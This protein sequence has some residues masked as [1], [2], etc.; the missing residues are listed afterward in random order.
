MDLRDL[1]S[2]DRLVGDL[3]SDLPRPI[4]TD[5]ARAALETARAT[6]L[7]G[8][9]ADPSVAAAQT[10]ASLQ[11]ARPR[12]VINATGVLLHTNLGRAPIHPKAADVAAWTATG[13]S[14][15]EIDLADGGRG[16]RTAYLEALLGTITGA[17]AALAVNNNAAAL[18][19]TLIALARDREVPV[20]RGELIEIGGSYRLPELM[21]A[22]GC[23]LIEVGTT[24]RTRIGDFRAAVGG[25]TAMLL[26]VHP[27]NYRVAGF[28]EEAPLEEMVVLGRESGLP[29]VFDIGSG[30]IDERA[31][32]LAGP[33]PKWLADE[34]GVLQSIEAGVDLA[35]FSGDK[36]FGGPQAGIIVGRQDLIG[37][38]RRHPV[39]RAMR[40]DGASLNALVITAEM[41]ADG[42]AGELPF[43]EMATTAV[44]ELQ[45][46]CEQIA[47][48][49]HADCDVIDAFSTIGA[50]S[51]PGSEVPSRV[52]AFDGPDVDRLYLALLSG[53]VPVVA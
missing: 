30:L 29:T 35:M 36:L 43:W 18:F 20:S 27:S 32:W 4:V 37:Q 11:R 5:I 34:P 15:V 48:H 6:I 16:G 10:A 21:D 12:G 45:R 39:S 23:R 13:Y 52:M 31:P 7:A 25:D 50:G 51:V 9:E 46:R 24:N 8:G 3:A 26:K 53:Q 28:S 17:E 47:E 22:S 44:D 1:P 49:L 19:L 2:V 14:N 42:R 40:L 33:P 41:Y 38:L